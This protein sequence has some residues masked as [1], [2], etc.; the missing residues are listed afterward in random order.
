VKNIYQYIANKIIRLSIK[1]SVDDL[2]REKVWIIMKYIMSSKLEVL[3]NQLLDGIIINSFY[4]VFRL[5]KEK[6]I[7]FD[8]II[9]E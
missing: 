2:M 6:N 7:R 9:T 3:R 8:E 4:V 5:T 1:L